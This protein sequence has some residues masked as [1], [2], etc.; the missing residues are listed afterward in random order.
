M[1]ESLS[2]FFVISGFLGEIEDIGSG[3]VLLI[4]RHNP[5]TKEVVKND[6]VVL[7]LR[8]PKE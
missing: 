4:K 3:K 6:P 2:I 8:K 7:I 5:C 1:H